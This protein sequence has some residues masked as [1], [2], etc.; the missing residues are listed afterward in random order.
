MVLEMI[1]GAV[2]TLTKTMVTLE[3]S[4]PSREGEIE[5]RKADCPIPQNRK[6]RY[7][8]FDACNNVY[9]GFEGQLRG[10]EFC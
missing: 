7:K 4:K 8:T 9:R 6:I 10:H 1:V 2:R 5:G 3:I